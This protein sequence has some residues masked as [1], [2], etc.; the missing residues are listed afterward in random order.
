M[1]YCFLEHGLLPEVYLELPEKDK[2]FMQAALQVRKEAEEKKEQSNTNG[3]RKT[4][5]K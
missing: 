4:I 5:G 3:I 2:V 1:A